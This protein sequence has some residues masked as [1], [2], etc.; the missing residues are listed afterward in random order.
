MH[1]S[2]RNFFDITEKVL[3][4]FATIYIF[5]L[6]L[7]IEER[8]MSIFI[9]F[10]LIY[11]FFLIINNFLKYRREHSKKYLYQIMLGIAIL[12]AVLYRYLI[13]FQL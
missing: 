1:E 4:F 8:N 5:I 12:A 7:F 2:N 10:G 6:P 9:S 13:L 3:L 11:A